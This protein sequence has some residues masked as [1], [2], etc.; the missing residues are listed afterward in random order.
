MKMSTIFRV[1]IEAE[2]EV[3]AIASTAS[4]ASI[5]VAAVTTI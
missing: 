1:S 2:V 5:V 4:T 3:V